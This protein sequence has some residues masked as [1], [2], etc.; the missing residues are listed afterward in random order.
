L[1]HFNEFISKFF[2]LFSQVAHSSLLSFQLINGDIQGNELFL[3]FQHVINDAGEFM[4]RGRNRFR[5]SEVGALASVEAPDPS[6]GLS[7]C[8]GGHS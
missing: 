1:L 2:S 5:S 4:R 6:I 7:R 3:V 8:Q